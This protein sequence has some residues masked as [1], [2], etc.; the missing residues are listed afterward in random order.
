[1]KFKDLIKAPESEGYLKNSSKLITA[2]F[3]IGGIAY[4]PTK[5]YGT[6]IALVIALM[7]L[8]GQKLLLSQINKDF[9]EMY[10]AKSQFEQN[11]NPEYLTFILLRSDQI[12]QDNKVLSQKAKKELS[13]L[14]QY[15]TEKSKQI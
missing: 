7:I 6:V 4:Y 1:M 12:L 13:A 5:G 9:A 3:I 2:L 11:Q 14:Q 10:F 8:V 15:A